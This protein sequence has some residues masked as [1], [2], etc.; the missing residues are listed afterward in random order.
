MRNKRAYSAPINWL[1]TAALTFL[2]HFLYT[3]TLVN[4]VIK[5]MVSVNVPPSIYSTRIR[6]RDFKWNAHENSNVNLHERG[7]FE[8]RETL[9]ILGGASLRNRQG[10]QRLTCR[11]HTVSCLIS[12]SVL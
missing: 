9:V 4:S 2:G 5:V 1:G 8:S 12:S 7:V 6:L 3:H 11:S 10:L